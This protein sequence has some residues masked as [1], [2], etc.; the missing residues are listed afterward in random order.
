MLFLEYAVWGSYLISLGMFLASI[1]L[2]NRIGWFFAAQG[3]TALFM[4]ALCGIIADRHVRANRLLGMCHL[5]SAVFMGLTAYFSGMSEPDFM[6]IYLPFSLGILFF[7]PTISLAN[8][9]CFMLIK[10]QGA[11]SAEE[12]PHIRLW[13]TIGFICSMWA[14]NF[15][16]ISTSY[17]QLVL[18]AV[19][20]V[21][22]ALYCIT[23]PECPI[24]EKSVGKGLVSAMGYRGFRLFKQKDMAFFF[25][26]AMGF[27][28]CLHISNGYA[29][30]FLDSFA[31]KPE[32]SDSILVGNSMFVLSISQISE[33]FCVLLIP[34][35]LKRFGIK[36]VFLVAALAWMVRYVLLAYGNPGERAWM[37]ILSMVM[38]GL[39]FDFFNVAASIAGS[40]AFCDCFIADIAILVI[41]S[42]FMVSRSECSVLRNVI[43]STPISTA[44]STNHS[45]LS[46]N[47][48]GA[49]AICRYPLHKGSCLS[50]PS[51][52]T[53]HLF[54][55]TAVITA[56]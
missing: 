7:I 17:M 48:A 51:I 33:A 1:G 53:R 8:S 35:C 28:I 13:G 56:S 24:S 3:I 29:G 10:K 9:V 5:L 40:V 44:F 41:R 26:I 4:P 16:G 20:G 49:T 54:P 34:F 27:G 45:F 23:L 55:D 32:Y 31:V 19:L 25:L 37:L 39:A 21:V 30:P 47:F 11:D 2:G 36:R 14:V 38:Y 12:F 18:R 46:I 15:L 43:L 42:I 22:M 50:L 6:K 52:W